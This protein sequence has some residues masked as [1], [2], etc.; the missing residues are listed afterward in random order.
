MTR[1][2]DLAELEYVGDDEHKGIAIKMCK[3][4]SDLYRI[5]NLNEV[6]PV[7]SGMPRLKISLSDK[8]E[9]EITNYYDDSLS[10]STGVLLGTLSGIGLAKKKGVRLDPDGLNSAEQFPV[11][12]ALAFNSLTDL[13]ECLN[14]LAKT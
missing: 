13:A 1:V 6:G 5:S 10:K 11:G 14:V 4:I 9:I 2:T 12:A 7:L 8:A 3:M